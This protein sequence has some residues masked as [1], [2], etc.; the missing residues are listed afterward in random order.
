MGQKVLEID[1]SVAVAINP[2][3]GALR[4]GSVTH[5]PFIVHAVLIDVRIGFVAYHSRNPSRLLD[6]GSG[7]VPDVADD[8]TVDGIPWPGTCAPEH[9]FVGLPRIKRPDRH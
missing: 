4:I 5:L 9:T 7:P 3:I 6:D 2:W 8:A 1:V